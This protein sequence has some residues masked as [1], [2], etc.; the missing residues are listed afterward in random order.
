[1]DFEY[2]KQH[3]VSPPIKIICQISALW[4]D[5]FD[6]FQSQK[7]R[8]LNF[9]K[10]FL[11]AF[12]SCLS[13]VFGL[14]SAN[15]GCIFGSKRW[16]LTPKKLKSWLKFW[17]SWRSI[18]TIFKVKKVVFLTF[19]NLFWSYSELVW[20]LFLALKGHLCEYFWL[21]RLIYDLQ[22]QNI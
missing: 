17:S 16:L 21:E 8:F 4:E 18:L 9:F 7:S 19:W 1:M 3:L 2:L 10:L 14:K 22:K 11:E 20:A 15:F 6:N 13:I 5:N 12:R